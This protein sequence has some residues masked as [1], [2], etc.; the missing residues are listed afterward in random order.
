MGAGALASQREFVVA[1]EQASASLAVLVESQQTAFP[2]RL[3][4][5]KFGLEVIV[6]KGVFSPKH[7][8]GWETFTRNFPSVRGEDVLEIGCGT[9]ITAL[10]LAR[11][12]ARSV[13]ALD[14]NAKAVANTLAN[15]AHNRTTK[16][17]S[18]QSDIFSTLKDDERFDTIYWNLPFIYV[19][20]TYEYASMLERGLFDP[21][22]CYTERFLREG[23]NHLRDDGRLI[24]GL[25]DFADVE[26]FHA[27]ARQY[28]YEVKL[29]ASESAREINKV[30]FQL[31]ELRPWR[32]VYYAM[33]FTGVGYQEIVDIRLKRNIEAAAH[34]LELLEQFVGV[35]EESKFVA[36]AYDPLFVVQKDYA[37]LAQA[38]FVVIDCN[39]LSL[40]RDCEHAIA[41][42]RY[43]KR[44][45]AIVA[46]ANYRLHPYLRYY[47]DYIVES[48]S[49]ALQLMARLSVLAL[50]SV[51]AAFPRLLKDRVDKQIVE[52][53]QRE[54]DHGVLPLLPTELVRRWRQIFGAEFPRAIEIIGAKQRRTVRI[55]TIKASA[56]DF[57]DS[58]AK[59]RWATSAV[60][61]LGDCFRVT[62]PN[63]ALALGN[64]REHAAGQFYVQDLA[65]QL[66]PL[67]LNPMPNHRVLD[68]CAAPGSKT[69]QMA[70]MMENR[71]ELIAVDI[72]AERLEVLSLAA[73]RLGVT[74]IT[75][76]VGDGTLIASRTRGSFDRVLVDAPCSSE[77]ILSQKPHKLFEWS[78]W[79][80]Q[81]LIETQLKLIF[82]GFDA[83]KCGG[84]MVYSTCTVAPEEN[85]AIVH[86]LLESRRDA[87]VM[88]LPAFSSAIKLRPALTVWSNTNYDASIA[89]ARR[90]YPW[91]NDSN[92]FFFARIV[93]TEQ[94]RSR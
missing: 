83:L 56:R 51:M 89:A 68:L 91:D 50:P 41:K 40:G 52:N 42:E 80:T 18:R 76:V 5:P 74:I 11:Q 57:I 59:H 7:F 12:H 32:K 46:D 60:V 66:A 23:K 35:E 10:Y 29:L 85:E 87:M 93:K 47:S 6:H 92:G 67:A 38:D 24:A 75:A 88:P 28:R 73:R 49:A 34:S 4:L 27:L 55:N 61:G 2:Y 33:Q 58:A 26:R 48:W 79:G 9:G 65:S 45:V 22:Y 84:E 81:K 94:E 17:F 15:S 77:G 70:A 82:A 69:T 36:H 64:S 44:V 43:D 39:G 16:L 8:H 21:G 63:G 71:G 54:P 86:A 14:I 72:S 90:I 19:P 25:A 1:D 62:I 37:L 3:N 13:L 31:Y 78:L 53:C 20:P 30:E